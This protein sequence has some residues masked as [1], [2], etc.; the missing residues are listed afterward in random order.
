VR[1][2]DRHP[3]CAEWENNSPILRCQ[4]QTEALNSQSSGLRACID[5]GLRATLELPR[6]ADTTGASDQMLVDA[7]K[8]LSSSIVAGRHLTAQQ[9]VRMNFQRPRQISSRF[10][11]FGCGDIR[12]IWDGHYRPG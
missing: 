3:H 1:I 9:Q 8:W 5:D 7:K 6:D 4:D 2:R 11:R 10:R 12:P